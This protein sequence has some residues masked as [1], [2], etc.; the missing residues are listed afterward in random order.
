MFAEVFG[1]LNYRRIPQF[2]GF[3]RE[4]L[5]IQLLFAW[6]SNASRYEV[7]PRRTLARK[8]IELGSKHYNAGECPS[9][10]EYLAKEIDDNGKC[11]M[12]LVLECLIYSTKCKQK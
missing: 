6:D 10:F 8:I 11:G 7:E 3:E 4:K 12:C 5:F 9:E 2:R 1:F